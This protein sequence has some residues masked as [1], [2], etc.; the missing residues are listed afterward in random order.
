MLLLFY[1]NI[2]LFTSCARVKRTTPNDNI[3]IIIIML[4]DSARILFIFKVHFY[5]STLSTVNTRLPYCYILSADFVCIYTRIVLLC[6][7]TGCTRELLPEEKH[8]F[9]LGSSTYCVHIVMIYFCK[10]LQ[11]YKRENSK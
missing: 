2:P 6:V 1:Y 7:V 4:Y 8:I 10:T 9:H 3:I 5:K 11:T